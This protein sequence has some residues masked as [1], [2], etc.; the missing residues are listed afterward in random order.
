MIWNRPAKTRKGGIKAMHMSSDVMKL[1]KSPLFI[2][3]LSP[4]TP[5]L[6]LEPQY[7]HT[8]STVTSILRPA[9]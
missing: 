5:V 1:K 6:Q 3:A 4:P 7:L 2:T 9:V 8:F